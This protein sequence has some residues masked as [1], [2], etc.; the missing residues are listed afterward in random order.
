MRGDDPQVEHHADG[1]EEQAEQDVAERLDVL[2]DLVAIL[3]LRDQH[4]REECAQRERQARELGQRRHAQRDQQH[5]QHEQLGRALARDHMEPPAHRLLAE[6]QDQRQGDARLQQRAT[7]RGDAA[8]SGARER[9]NEDQ[10]RDDGQVLEQQD[11]HRVAPVRGAQ[12][13]ALCQ[14][15]R[16][17]GGRAHRQRAANDDAGP[18]AIAQQLNAQPSSGGRDG[19]LREAQPE[20]GAAHRAQL[21][22]AELEADREHQEHDAELGELPGR[23]VVGHD[24]ERMRPERD[25]DDQVAEDRR[26]ADDAAGGHDHDRGRQQDEDQEQRLRHRSVGLRWNVNTTTNAGRR[27]STPA[28]YF[29]R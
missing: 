25:A 20:Y 9:G 26:Q 5:V 19:N 11:A 27:G 14:H 1:D 29:G 8:A 18:P 21:G 22:Q 13:R 6:E 12:L 28:V 16:H 23:L 24:G 10:E 7:H 2:L 17:D 3:G 4:A 15:L